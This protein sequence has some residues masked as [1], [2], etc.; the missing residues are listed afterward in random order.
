MYGSRPRFFFQAEDGIR[1]EIVTGVQ[2][3]AIA[4]SDAVGYDLEFF[5][6]SFF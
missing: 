4:H 1:D 2:T 3:I 5:D 6:E